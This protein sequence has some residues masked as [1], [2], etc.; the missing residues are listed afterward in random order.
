MAR[1]PA[2]WS[3]SSRRAGPAA[4][5]GRGKPLLPADAGAPPA[6]RRS[7]GDIASSS[8]GYLRGSRPGDQRRR[9]NFITVLAGATAW[10]FAARAQEHRR[11]ARTS[12]S[13]CRSDRGGLEACAGWLVADRC[14]QAAPRYSGQCRDRACFPRILRHADCN[15]PAS[16]ARFFPGLADSV[17]CSI[18]QVSRASKRW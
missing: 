10:I 1:I 15:V 9:R 18:F 13:R 6:R 7:A 12:T 8:S 16:A 3:R 11:V 2:N 14:S 4:D 5:R 17:S